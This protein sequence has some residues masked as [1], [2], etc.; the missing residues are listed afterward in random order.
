M[1]KGVLLGLIFSAL[2]VSSAALADER[3]NQLILWYNKYASN[4]LDYI[5]YDG[6]GGGS[7]IPEHENHPKGELTFEQKQQ[8]VIDCE[9]HIENRAAAAKTAVAI[10]SDA[11]APFA[12]GIGPI[13][14]GLLK[15]THEWAQDRI[16]RERRK[17]CLRI[18]QEVYHINIPDSW[19]AELDSDFPP[20]SPLPE[21]SE[22]PGCGGRHCPI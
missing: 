18:F 14:A 21:P 22:P 2:F 19:F 9:D 10:M 4:G 6:N 17:D 8:M 1:K 20:M 16:V 3:G 13:A 11:T 5:A 12:P 15:K 7:S